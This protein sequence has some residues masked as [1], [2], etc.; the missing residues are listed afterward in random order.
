MSFCGDKPVC[1]AW[2]GGCLAIESALK[3][4]AHDPSS[5]DVENCTD[6]VLYERQCWVTTCDVRG[7]NAFGAMILQRKQFSISKL[8]VDEIK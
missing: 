8:G 2:D 1:S 5:I 3:R 4:T 6:P 7:R